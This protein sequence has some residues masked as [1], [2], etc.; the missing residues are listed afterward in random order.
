[1]KNQILNINNGLKNKFNPSVV[2]FKKTFKQA[3]KLGIDLNNTTEYIKRDGFYWKISFTCG[4][5][6]KSLGGRYFEGINLLPVL[7]SL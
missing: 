7:K 4:N 2:K 1:M 5:Y 6:S 3:E